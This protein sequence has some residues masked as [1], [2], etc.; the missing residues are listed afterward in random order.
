[1]MVR[2]VDSRGNLRFKKL[3]KTG[4][5][6]DSDKD[7]DYTLTS[8]GFLKKRKAKRQG[9]RSSKK[10]ADDTSVPVSVQPSS[11]P[12]QQFPPIGDQLTASETMDL[13]SS[14]QRYTYS[15]SSHYY[16]SYRFLGSGWSVWFFKT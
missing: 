6:G 11:A 8:P 5:T 1:M 7:K 4:N 9:V 14:P 13:V 15:T 16:W 12:E 2:F 10:A 3:K